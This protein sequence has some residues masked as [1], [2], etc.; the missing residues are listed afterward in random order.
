MTI[1]YIHTCYRILDPDKSRDFYVDKL[2]MKQVGEMHFSDATNYFFAVEEDPA[3]PMLELTHNHGRTEPYEKGNGYAHVAFVVD[4]LEGTVAK[5]E[6]QGVE[7]SRWSP[8]R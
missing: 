5:L 7:R 3:S 6:E 8:R 2:G 4:D 1:R